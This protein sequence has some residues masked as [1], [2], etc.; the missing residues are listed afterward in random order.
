[1]SV[2]GQA[3]CSLQTAAP[4]QYTFV[5]LSPSTRAFRLPE[6]WHVDRVVSN[7]TLQALRVGQ[8]FVDVNW[9]SASTIRIPAALSGS[10]QA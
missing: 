8:P 3:G 2:A 10:L 1:M 4:L 5:P 9:D 6:P 7:G